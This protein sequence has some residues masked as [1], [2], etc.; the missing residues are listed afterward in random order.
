MTQAMKGVA[1]SS[2][3]QGRIYGLSWLIG[4]VALFAVQGALRGARRQP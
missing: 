3:L 4:F 1:G 2:A